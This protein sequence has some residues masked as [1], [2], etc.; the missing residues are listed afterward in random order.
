MSPRLSSPPARLAARFGPSARMLAARLAGLAVS[1]L[2][3]GLAVAPAL[4]QVRGHPDAVVRADAPGAVIE[5]DLFG[6]FAEH[7][8]TGIYGG[9][10]VGPDSSIPNVRGIRSDVVAA[11]RELR[12]P[13]VRWPGGCYA[14]EYHWRNGVGPVSARRRTLNYSWGNV[15]EPNTFGTHEFMDFIDQ[16]GAEA[17]V[18]VNVATGSA[19]EAAD[20]FEYMTSS[21]P[22]DLALARQA[23]GRAAPW[24]IKYLGIGNE[25]WACG[26]AMTAQAYID[27]MK[28][29]A[30][31][32][33]NLNPDQNGP[34]RFIRSPDAMR[35]I[36]VGPRDGDDAAWT[37][38]LMEAWSKRDKNSWGLEAIQLHHY[39]SGPAGVWRDPGSG[40]SEHDYAITLKNTVAVDKAITDQSA[41]MD[42]YDPDRQVALSIDEFGIWLAGAPG[43]NG[44]FLQQENSLRDGIVASIYLNTF[45]RHADRVRIAAIAQM[46]NVLQAMLL[47]DGDRMVRTPTYWVYRMYR[48]FQNARVLP[49]EMDGGSWVSGDVSLKQVDGL[50]ARAEDGSILVALTNFDPG[51]PFTV[52]ARVTGERP[53]TVTG[54]TLTGPAIDSVN[55]FASSDTVRPHPITA[56]VREGRLQVVLP[57]RSVTVLRLTP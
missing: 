32:T 1:V 24:K 20:W 45:A 33:R 36:A 42:R 56:T 48:P 43:T 17:Y 7:L 23:N 11:L 41:I 34:V 37:E 26:G 12:V 9:V 2:A 31:F 46:V 39:T 8:G 14:E 13:F 54:E 28:T 49:L 22:T 6:Q 10:W 47:T 3:L 55:S 40:F 57:P 29:F 5:R 30:Q 18:N 38:A 19:E 27:R 21:Q 4:A 53:G 51:K 15:V 50:A 44:M 25:S 52:S 35:R 16:I